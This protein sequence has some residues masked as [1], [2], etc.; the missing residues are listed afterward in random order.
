MVICVI[1]QNI[2]D[3]SSEYFLTI[4]IRQTELTANR[5][6]LLITLGIGIYGSQSLCMNLFPPLRS[7]R[8]VKNDCFHPLNITLTASY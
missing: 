2:E 7:N 1:R 4:R 8:L 6:Q 3:H 5:Y